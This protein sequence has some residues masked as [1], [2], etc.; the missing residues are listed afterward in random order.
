MPWIQIN[1]SPNRDIWLRT[2]SIIGLAPA[3]RHSSG[4]QLLLLS[5]ATLDVLEPRDELLAR[6]KEEEGTARAERRVGFP[7][8]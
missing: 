3:E 7:G 1:Q 8:E 5:G 4:S 2:E 6:I